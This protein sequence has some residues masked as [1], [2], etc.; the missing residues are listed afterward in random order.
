MHLATAGSSPSLVSHFR[1]IPSLWQGVAG[2]ATL[3]L[4]HSFSFHLPSLLLLENLYMSVLYQE[5]RENYWK[6]YK[7]GSASYSNHNLSFWLHWILV[8]FPFQ[9]VQTLLLWWISPCMIVKHRLCKALAIWSHG[10]YCWNLFLLPISVVAG[11][12][13]FSILKATSVLSV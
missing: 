12:L 7:P 8:Y 6:K 13:I 11:V 4:Q 10:S 3:R 1:N 5:M 2:V 9:W